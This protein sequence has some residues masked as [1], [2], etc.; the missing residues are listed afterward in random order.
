MRIKNNSQLQQLAKLLGMKPDDLSDRIIQR[1]QALG[2]I[3]CDCD[4]GSPIL[5]ILHH[6]DHWIS[7]TTF[8]FG[9]WSNEIQALFL[10]CVVIGSGDCEICGGETELNDGEYFTVG[11]GYTTPKEK[12]YRWRE[13][14]CVLC[15]HKQITGK[16][17]DPDRK[18]DSKT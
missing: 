16:V 2:I 5:D 1:L 8:I 18:H 10:E 3:R 6:E 7:I 13:D 11:D 15:G 12:E 14:K 9:Q 4:Y 17:P